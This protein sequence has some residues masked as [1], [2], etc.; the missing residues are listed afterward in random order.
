MVR[1][2]IYLESLDNITLENNISSN[3]LSDIGLAFYCF[4]NDDIYSGQY[5]WNKRG[6]ELLVMF[7][8]R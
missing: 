5:F 4:S 7:S 1:D 3:N 8:K 6:Q 2:G